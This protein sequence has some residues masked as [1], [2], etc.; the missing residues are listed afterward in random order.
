MIS[1]RAVPRRAT[2]YLVPFFSAVLAVG[3]ILVA[4]VGSAAQQEV[5]EVA[6][7]GGAHPVAAQ[8][9]AAGQ[10]AGPESAGPPKPL[11]L[12]DYPRWSR[13]GN[14]AL[15]PDGV[16]MA[17]SYDPLDGDNTL[18][19]RNLD[20][21]A[22]HEVARGSGPRFSDDSQWVAFM[23]SP[24]SEEG[25]RRGGGPGGGGRGR[26]GNGENGAREA[27]IMD[28]ADG[29]T[30]S[31]ADAASFTFSEGGRFFAVKRRKVD[32]EA[33]HEGTDLT[34][35]DLSSGV[36]QNIGNVDEFAF[37]EQSNALAYT[38][39][40]AGGTGNGLYVMD[41][42]TRMLRPLDTSS[43]RYAQLSWNEEGQGLAVLRGATEEGL[44]QRT[45]KLIAFVN[46]GE[47]IVLT[48][49]DPAAS[50]D[51]PE[52]MVLSELR[53]LD[54]SDDG[55]RIFVG[56]KEQEEELAEQDEDDA[57]N[58]DVWHWRD[59]R[60]QSVQEVRA[61][62]DRQA[63]YTSVIHLD[64][65]SFVQL[66]DEAMPT[67]ALS[68]DGS[69][70]I[71]RYDKQYRYDVTWGGSKADYYRVDA[72]TGERKLVVE[73]LGR[74]M[75]LSPDGRWY[76]YL[77]D[78]TVFVEDV[79][80]EEMTDLTDMSGV[81]FVNRQ[82]DH[83]YELPAYGLMG[84][85]E[86]G[87]WV[88]LNHRYDLWALPLPGSGGEPVNLTAGLGDRESIRFRYVNLEA[89]GGGGGRGGF[90][91][92]GGPTK[93]DIDQPLLLSA[94]GDRSKK[95]GYYSV[96]FGEEP[97]SL[98]FEDKSIGA[99]R[100]A[101]DADRV[102]FTEQ[103]FV[104][105]PDYW[106]ADDLSAAGLSRA[107]RVTEANP[108]QAEYLWSPGSVLIDY[109]DERGNELQATLSLPAGYEE[110]KQYPMLVYFYELMSQNHHRYSMPTYDDRPHFSA[111][112]SN[113]Y[114][115]LRPDIVYTEGRPGT[116]ALDDLTS[117]IQKV[118]ELGYAD[119]ERIGL[120]GHSWGGYQSSFVLTQTD[121]FAAV[122]TGAPVTNLT[123]FYGELY[124]SSGNPQ[125]GI[126]ERGQVRMGVS[127][128]EDWDLY[129]SQSP[130]HQAEKIT[131][132]FLIL[133][134]TED[135]SVDWHQGLEYYNAARR[136]GKEVI[137]LSYPGE[138]HH[139]SKLANQKDFQI[140]MKQFFDHYL[141]DAPAPAWMLEGVSFLK[142]GA[143]TQR[144]QR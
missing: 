70:G 89:A 85:S 39:D 15:S 49:F 99:L 104:E 73:S 120:Q 44:V 123:S 53:A 80:T 121:I 66:T 105:F 54:W 111:Y 96:T 26:G 29:E 32:R 17:H 56:I 113:G 137:L 143:G 92:G 86:D 36:V 74:A 62:R 35:R 3:V 59:E 19:L 24:E 33:E 65:R 108:Q 34:L 11:S 30:I 84:W 68:E 83:P 60:V 37:N 67:I 97:Q 134:G 61:N 98:V 64:D 1:D 88:F 28:L 69:F 131:T 76:L 130:V 136:L 23:V 78:E 63:T 40:A 107:R 110:G 46:R 51:F 52:G 5:V 47:E 128:Y 75:G 20:S 94:Y 8:Q 93:I 115:V 124:K 16:W 100:K 133:H 126:M 141:K 13:I 27:V 132:P 118:V 144:E 45:N 57:A 38:V 87:D 142:K 106:T 127:P 48:D 14:V 102:V 43:E 7:P 101:K 138:G 119:P 72:T 91:G 95:S 12:D 122:V 125:Q 129:V 4:P 112:T 117:S 9:G 2:R 58:V 41:L 139:L 42:E 103:T 71:G 114:L 50:A 135:G 25:G 90:G 79:D 55:S 109:T 31:T 10:G 116:S 22:L 82:D 140:R 77:E 21:D 18:Y 6:Q 81:D